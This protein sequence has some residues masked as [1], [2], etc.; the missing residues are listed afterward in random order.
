MSHNNCIKTIEVRS[1]FLEISCR[2]IIGGEELGIQQYRMTQ[3]QELEYRLMTPL[4]RSNHIAFNTD[5][6]YDSLGS[7]RHK[8]QIWIGENKDYT[9]SA[10]TVVLELN[11]D[12]SV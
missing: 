8:T 3:T 10:F 11:K 12:R 2:G 1:A 4:W 7:I 9:S 6:S 5:L